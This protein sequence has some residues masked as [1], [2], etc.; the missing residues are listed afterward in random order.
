MHYFPTRR[1][2]PHWEYPGG[3][4]CL[5]WRLR[6]D[7]FPLNDEERGVVLAVIRRSD[8]TQCGLLAVVVMDDH[9][10]ALLRPAGGTTGKYLASAWKSISSH[11]LCGTGPRR[12][13]L[14]QRNYFDRW[15]RS[16]DQIRRCAE[17][18][19]TN[20]RRRWPGLGTYPHLL[21]PQ[22]GDSPSR[23]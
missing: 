8:P 22:L 21:G 5:T 2:V 9:V 10:H 7:H 17:Y 12:A 14:W 3:T 11:E 4:V 13:P 15:M 23:P 1:R 19:A 16:E 18:I 6:R 20:P